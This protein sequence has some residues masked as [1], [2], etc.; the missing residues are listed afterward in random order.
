[1]ILKHTAGPQRLRRTIL[2]GQEEQLHWTM[3]PLPQVG[4]MLHKEE[5]PRTVVSS[6][7]KKEPKVYIQLFHHCRC[8][9]GSISGSCLTGITEE[10]F[11]A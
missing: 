5:P 7:R 1:M 6:V 2:E 4:T 10:I 8:F 3:L 11:G 9:P